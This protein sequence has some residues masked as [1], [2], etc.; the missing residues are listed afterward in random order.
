VLADNSHL[1][2]K[3]KGEQRVAMPKQKELDDTCREAADTE[4]Q[5]LNCCIKVIGYL[6]KTLLGALLL[7]TSCIHCNFLGVTLHAFRHAA[8]F[9]Q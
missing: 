6:H 2:Q 8:Q 1:E 3:L 4:K 9:G 7:H 5:P